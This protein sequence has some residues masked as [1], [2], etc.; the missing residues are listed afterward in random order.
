MGLGHSRGDGPGTQPKHLAYAIQT[1]PVVP[2][3]VSEYAACAVIVY[4]CDLPEVARV[5]QGATKI[6]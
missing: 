3:R 2:K 1:V 6:D 5:K 4:T